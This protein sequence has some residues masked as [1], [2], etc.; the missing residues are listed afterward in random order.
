[1]NKS[2]VRTKQN[3]TQNWIGCLTNLPGEMSRE[4]KKNCTK[5]LSKFPVL[6]KINS[7][8]KNSTFGDKLELSAE[9]YVP[10]EESF[11]KH[12]HTGSNRDGSCFENRTQSKVN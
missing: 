8:K 11:R 12:A 9:V 3:I 6:Q 4:A 5:N 1:M 7:L 10:D 2:N